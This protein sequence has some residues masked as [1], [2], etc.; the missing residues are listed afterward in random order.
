MVRVEGESPKG[1][2]CKDKGESEKARATDQTKAGK[3]SQV[4]E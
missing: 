4:G 3:E 2:C 1:L